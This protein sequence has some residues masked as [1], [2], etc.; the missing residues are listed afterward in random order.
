METVFSFTLAKFI[1]RFYFVNGFTYSGLFI[2]ALGVTFFML[3]AVSM[4]SSWRV[5]IDKQSKTALITGGIYKYS[6][7]PAFVGFDFM[8]IGVFLTFPDILTVLVMTINMIAFHLLILQEERHLTEA[9]G[10]EYI[11]YKQITLRYLFFNK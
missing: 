6:R 10:K 11:Q 3:A 8:F 1:R 4:K 9:F 7:N 5:G 2:T